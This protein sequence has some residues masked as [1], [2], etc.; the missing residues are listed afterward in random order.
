[1]SE[2]CRAGHVDY[3]PGRLMRVDAK[4]KEIHVLQSGETE[5]MTMP[6]DYLVGATGPR[7]DWDGLVDPQHDLHNGDDEVM[8]VVSVCTTPHAEVGLDAYNTLVKKKGGGGIIVGALQGASCFGPAYEYAMLLDHEL[9]KHGIRDI[10]PITF[11]TSE[12]YVGHMGL[13]GVGDSHNILVDLLE[14]QDIKVLTNC[15]VDKIDKKK[16][17]VKVTQKTLPDGEIEEHIKAGENIFPWKPSVGTMKYEIPAS[18]LMM[19]PMFKGQECWSK[20]SKG[21]ADERGMIV[22]DEFMR[23]PIYPEIYGVGVC[24]KLP[25]VE[26]TPV[27]TGAPKTGYLIESMGTATAVNIG[28]SM[29]AKRAGEGLDTHKLKR[30]SLDALCL[31]D[32]GGNRGAMFL[33]SPEMPPRQRTET[34]YG[35]IVK[36]A[37]VAFEKYFLFKIRTG[38]ADPFHEKVMLKSLGIERLEH[39]K[40]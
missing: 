21:V 33:A 10:C 27:Q 7:L 18:F 37:K 4:K 30:P 34:I 1:M 3:I 14:K 39:S 24:A 9:R 6:Y 20:S 19:I 25:P 13:A 22:I 26:A 31:T 23:N 15:V 5:E 36:L 28:E 29:K 35:G 11:V 40:R 12:P 16:A 38:D 17:I 8:M 32:L 2:A